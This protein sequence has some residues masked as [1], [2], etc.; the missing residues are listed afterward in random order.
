MLVIVLRIQCLYFA[1]YE[2]QFNMIQPGN[3]LARNHEGHV[4]QIGQGTRGKKDMTILH[5]QFK[6]A[7]H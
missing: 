2:C 6:K 1:R 4:I 5:H 3:L 7:I